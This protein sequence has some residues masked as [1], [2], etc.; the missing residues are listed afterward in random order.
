[1]HELHISKC[2]QLQLCIFF[3]FTSSNFSLPH[4]ESPLGFSQGF[5]VLFKMLKKVCIF[6]ITFHLKWTPFWIGQTK[7][8]K[9]C[10]QILKV[11]EF[12]KEWRIGP[13]EQTN[14]SGWH[15]PCLETNNLLLQENKVQ[16]N[17]MTLWYLTSYTE[18]PQWKKYTK[19]NIFREEM[20][21]IQ[22]SCLSSAG[23]GKTIKHI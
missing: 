14:F 1:M 4:P 23:W 21:C 19:V 8:N 12:F 16:T 13:S 11:V 17:Y 3:P 22:C 18:E 20:R 15:G 9:F 2:Y 10:A 7:I 5:R 6:E